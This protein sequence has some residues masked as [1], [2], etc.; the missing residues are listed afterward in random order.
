MLIF[1]KPDRPGPLRNFLK[2]SNNGEQC[3][4]FPLLREQPHSENYLYLISNFPY[5]LLTVLMHAALSRGYSQL[6][7]LWLGNMN[8]LG[9]WHDKTLKWLWML[10]PFLFCQGS[11]LFLTQLTLYWSGWSGW[12]SFRSPLWEESR[13]STNC[14]NYFSQNCH[15]DSFS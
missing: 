3:Y 5:Y 6:N 9:L 10:M 14:W 11:P 1:I 13:N 8:N 2:Y 12:G 15:N 4:L 7:Q